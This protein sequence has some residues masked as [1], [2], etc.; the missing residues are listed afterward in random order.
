MRFL[1][2]ECMGGKFFETLSE[3]AFILSSE[4]SDWSGIEV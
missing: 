3:N 2:K 1:I 4:L